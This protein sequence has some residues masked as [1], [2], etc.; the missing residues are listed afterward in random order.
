MSTANHHR[1]YDSGYQKRRKKQRVDELI[2][3]QK[4]AIERFIR[5]EPLVN[6]TLDQGTTQN[7][8]VPNDGETETQVENIPPILEENIEEVPNNGDNMDGTS[9]DVNLDSSS[10]D[11]NVDTSFSPNIFDPRYWDSLGP[12]Q[13]DILAQKGPKRELSIVKGPKDRYGR[14]FSALAYTRILRNGEGCNRDWLVHSKELDKVFCFSCKLFTNGH[15]KVSD[16]DNDPGSSSEA[17]SLANNELGEFEFILAIVIWYEVLY[18]VNLVSKHLQAKD[19]LIDVA[20]EKVEGSISFFKKY[21]E[22]GFLEALE[23]TKG[24]ALEMDIDTKSLKSSCQNLEV[25]LA[26]DGNSDIDASELGTKLFK[27]EAIKVLLAFH[28]DIRK[29][30]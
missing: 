9:I 23:I 2:E 1:K 17:K 4:G 24:I 18:A 30:Q 5:K 6:Q 12:G 3:S 13:I 7:T 22:T 26:K 15:R 27:V 19:M 20:I 11:A 16:T 10:H 8:S 14:R 21:R 28:N 29:A 25:A